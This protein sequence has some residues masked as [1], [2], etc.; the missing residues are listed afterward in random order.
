MI[1][2]ERI[3]ANIV[4]NNKELISLYKFL[5]ATKNSAKFEV[6][7]DILCTKRVSNKCFFGREIKIDY[8]TT[9]KIIDAEIPIR[10]YYDAPISN[11]AVTVIILIL[12]KFNKELKFII[13]Y[14]NSVNKAVIKPY[15][16]LNIYRKSYIDFYDRRFA[17][18]EVDFT[19][20]IK[21]I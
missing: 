21:K 16:L 18:N 14:S 12:V 5:R 1:S 6:Y 10:K 15:I 7:L 2:D 9:I 20:I 11:K 19:K 17:Y 3:M 8:S 13:E 4:L